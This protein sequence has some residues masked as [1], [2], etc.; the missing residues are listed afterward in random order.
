[1]DKIINHLNYIVYIPQY[2]WQIIH[3][4]DNIFLRG[5]YIICKVFHFDENRAINYFSSF[6]S[7]FDF[8]KYIKFYIEWHA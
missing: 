2:P 1:M 7:N 5:T 6:Y 4:L 3:V 8:Y